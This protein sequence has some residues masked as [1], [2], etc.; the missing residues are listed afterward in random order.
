MQDVFDWIV[1]GSGPAGQ[2]AAVQAAKLKKKV[3]IVERDDWGG[4]CVHK[5]TIPSKTLK[6][7][8]LLNEARLENAW[9][10]I[11]YRKE[12][13][14]KNEAEIIA[15]QLDRNGVTRVRGQAS[16]V[17]TNAIRVGD[18][19]LRGSK[20]L[21]AVGTRPCRGPDFPWAIS[22]LYD[23]D[24]ILGMKESPESLL[25][26]GAGVIGC[27]Y[28]SIFARLGVQV[29]LV[30]RRKELLRSVD[31]EIVD[32]LKKHFEEASIRMEIG[33]DYKDVTTSAFGRGVEVEIGGQRQIFSAALVC[34]GRQGNI[35]SLGLE[36]IG[37]KA[38]DRGIIPVNEKYQTSLSH[39]YA[40]GDVIGAPALA[41][42]SSEQ[43]RL[44]ARHA[45]E[46]D[47][48]PFSKLFPYGIYTIPEI[49]SV[50]AQESELVKDGVSYVVGRASYG[51]L[52]RGQI[53]GDEHGL[54]KILVSRTD[55][56]ILGV[57][58]LGTGATE[59]VH[60]GQTAMHFEATVDFFVGN[61]F[62]YPTLAEA[63]KVASLN[64]QNQLQGS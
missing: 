49:S 47:S 64:A 24:T 21:V 19:L 53:L 26:I 16:F 17:D 15:R 62:N 4:A 5:G 7:A 31:Q 56:K 28:A 59:L 60:I 23:S 14:L 6:E 41:A 51:E 32:R 57:H 37:V 9:Q 20:F 11:L 13:V 55:R 39:I 25:V 33:A 63:Y 40:A 54:L 1:I 36:K 2:R 22:D 27:E 50:G 42:S 10:K 61:I 18:A 43:G 44:A 29:T 35:D 12:R 30:D 46:V 3:L 58:I 38:S 48:P 34:M 8:A 45:F 52:A